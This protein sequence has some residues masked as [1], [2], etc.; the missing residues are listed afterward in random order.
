MSQTIEQGDNHKLVDNLLCPS[1]GGQT[2]V[3]KTTYTVDLGLGVVVVRRI[4]AAIYT[5]CGDEWIADVTVQELKGIVG[6]AKRRKSQAEIV[7]YQDK[8]GMPN[9]AVTPI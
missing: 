7:D 6:D 4:P 9:N 5:W 1:C 2:Q 8:V 3:D